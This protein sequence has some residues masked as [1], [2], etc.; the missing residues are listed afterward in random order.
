MDLLPLDKLG[1]RETASGVIEFGVFF[2]WV[3]AEDGNRLFVKVI[4]E[5]DQFIQNVP[6]RRF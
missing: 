2:P 4:N 3:S 6:P 1:A 5:Q